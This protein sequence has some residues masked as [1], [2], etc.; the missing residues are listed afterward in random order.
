MSGAVAR[1]VGARVERVEDD[2][3]L[4]GRGHFADDVALPGMLHASF[5]RSPHAH[6]RIVAVD[7]EAARA[8]PGVHDVLVTAD[9]QGLVAERMDYDMG[10]PGHPHVVVHPL[11]DEP[12]QVRRDQHVVHPGQGARRLDVD[13]DDP[14][15]G[16]GASL[17]R[18]V[19][20]PGQGDVVG[21]VPAPGEDAVVL[22]AL[23]AGADDPGDGAAHAPPPWSSTARRT[24][25]A[26]LW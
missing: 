14:R 3:I 8:L 5:K 6:A 9:L 18:G 25:S 15:V 11:G 1:I 22:D 21:E 4:T 20:H 10:V 12:L 19:E 16:V 26:M 13:G 17:E 24:P 7:V 23:D 2:R